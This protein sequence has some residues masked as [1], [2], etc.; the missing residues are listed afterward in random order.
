MVIKNKRIHVN[1][2][3]NTKIR[4]TAGTIFLLF[5]HFDSMILLLHQKK[6]KKQSD[7]EPEYSKRRNEGASSNCFSRLQR[8][9]AQNLQFCALLRLKL[10]IPLISRAVRARDHSLSA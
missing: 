5:C 2:Y 4:N 1:S 3:E 9:T 7:Y 8:T 10:R 6:Q